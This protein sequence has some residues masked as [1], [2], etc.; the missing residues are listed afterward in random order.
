MQ[1]QLPPDLNSSI[2]YLYPVNPFCPT[3]L[4]SAPRQLRVRILRP[5]LSLVGGM[6]LP[7][8]KSR[9]TVHDTDLDIF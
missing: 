1:R 2:R 8:Y 9:P 5:L 6:P 7:C 4:A 3:M